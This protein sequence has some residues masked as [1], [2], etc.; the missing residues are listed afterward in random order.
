M[1]TDSGSARPPWTRTGTFLYTGLWRSS[2]SLL[3]PRSS[4]AYS[5]SSPLSRSASCTRCVYELAHDPNSFSEATAALTFS[6]VFSMAQHALGARL[7]TLLKM[8]LSTSSSS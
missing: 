7:W 1:M 4:S 8:P 6:V 3:L 2:S 5:N